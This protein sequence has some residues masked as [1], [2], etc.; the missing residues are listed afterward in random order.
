VRRA[1]TAQDFLRFYQTCKH[2]ASQKG[3]STL[4]IEDFTALSERIR[5][6]PERAAVLVSEYKGDILAGAVSLRVGPRVHYD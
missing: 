3:F 4:A 6:C 5:K 2:R 1:E